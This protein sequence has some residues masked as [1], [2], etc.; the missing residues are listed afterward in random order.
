MGGHPDKVAGS[1][2]GAAELGNQDQGQ[3]GGDQSMTSPCHP[4]TPSYAPRLL[5]QV[6]FGLQFS[7]ITRHPRLVDRLWNLALVRR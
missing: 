1:A 3:D 7:Q 5:K 2:A 4:T 6:H